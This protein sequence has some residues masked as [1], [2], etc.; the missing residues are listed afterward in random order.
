[1][2]NKVIELEQFT[3]FEEK[4]FTSIELIV[5]TLQSVANQLDDLNK[6]M[7][8]IEAKWGKE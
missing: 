4:V 7:A 6:R 5:K 8:R 1:M 2:E 3:T